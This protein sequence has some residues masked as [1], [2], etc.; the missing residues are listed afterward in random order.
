METGDNK[1]ADIAAI[2]IEPTG[3]HMGLEPVS[4]PFLSDLRS[5]TLEKE[6]VLIFDEVVTGFR[7]SK[8]GAQEYYGIT[9]DLTT[10]AKI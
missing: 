5:L 8:G 6:I 9:P 10:L 7:V 2:I 4:P 1:D 3:A